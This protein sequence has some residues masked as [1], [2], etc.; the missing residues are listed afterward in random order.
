MGLGPSPLPSRSRFPTQQVG[1]DDDQLQMMSSSSSVILSELLL[2]LRFSPKHGTGLFSSDGHPP[3]H[4][5]LTRNV[6]RRYW[7]PNC[8]WWKRLPSW[9]VR[10]YGEIKWVTSL[11]RVHLYAKAQHSP[12]N[13]STFHTHSSPFITLQ[14]IKSKSV[15]DSD[16]YRMKYYS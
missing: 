15:S 11:C 10:L 12:L 6:L 1:W 8:S 13:Q 9:Q 4:R 5:P 14:E 2:H 3:R 7:T 16:N